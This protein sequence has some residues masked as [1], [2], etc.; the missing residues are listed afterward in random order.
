MPAWANATAG[1]GAAVFANALV[2]PLDF[3]KTRL[4]VHDEHDA[5]DK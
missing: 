5:S 1:A 4:Q 3:A 2:Y